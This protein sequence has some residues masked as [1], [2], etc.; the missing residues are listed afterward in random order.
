MDLDKL[1]WLPIQEKFAWN[2]WAFFSFFNLWMLKQAHCALPAHN[3]QMSSVLK[4][5]IQW[6]L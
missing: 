5:Q 2:R 1:L 4:W 6:A 3:K